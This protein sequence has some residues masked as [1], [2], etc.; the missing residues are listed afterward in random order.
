[1]SDL[2]DFGVD[3]DAY[4]F[5]H[6]NGVDPQSIGTG[7]YRV[8]DAVEA[9]Y[10]H[11]LDDFTNRLGNALTDFPELSGTTVTVARDNP[12]DDRSA[13]AWPWSGIIFIP[14]DSRV[15]NVTIYHELG[16]LAIQTRIED[17]ED[18]PKTSEEFCSIF[19]MA[20][21]PTGRVDESV[22]PYLGQSEVSKGL[23]PKI[24]ETA[25]KYR[26]KRRNY[27]QRCRE[28]LN[29]EWAGPETIAE[30]EAL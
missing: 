17:G 4:A 16:H 18:L 10:T 26:E 29:G 9:Y 23:H 12:T 21:M 25:L 3:I 11:D 24:C 27:I 28:W 8:L 20:R 1:M 6:A 19:S 2:T 7:T 30:V 15:S 22:V 13:G 14:E 5:W